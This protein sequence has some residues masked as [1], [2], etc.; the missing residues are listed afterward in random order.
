[1][2]FWGAE[3]LVVS[4]IALFSLRGVLGALAP[5]EAAGFVAAL[6]AGATVF[7]RVHLRQ[8]KCLLGEL[9]CRR[10]LLTPDR[11]EHVLK[12]QKIVGGRFGEIA[13]REHYL[14]SRELFDLL[15][16]QAR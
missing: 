10:G 15:E 16:L 13:L 11:V 6:L 12:L 14:S 9:A 2:R 4:G 7:T 3:V 8:G 1:M 5:F